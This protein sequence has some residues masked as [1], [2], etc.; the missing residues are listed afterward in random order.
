MRGRVTF[1]VWLFQRYRDPRL[2]N[3]ASK[4]LLKVSVSKHATLEV[5]L[6]K[7]LPAIPT[8]AVL[9]RQI[10]MNLVTNASSLFGSNPRVAAKTNGINAEIPL[11]IR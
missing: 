8:N 11:D 6:A 5:N 4:P 3:D 7:D 1:H 2:R 9:I 10:V